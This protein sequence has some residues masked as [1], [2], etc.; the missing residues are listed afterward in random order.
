MMKTKLIL[1]ATLVGC[2]VFTFSGC[3]KSSSTKG[4]ALSA[5]QVSSQ[6]ALNITETLESGFGAF[7]LAGG[8][9]A[10]GNLG[11]VP[12]GRLRLNSAGDPLCGTIADTTLD[13]STNE[14][15][16][17]ASVKGHI[18]FA[19]TC[20]NGVVSGFNVTDN[21]AIAESS[22][23]F[24]VAFKLVE[25]LTVAAVNPN[26]D[27]TNITLNGSLSF[28]GDYTFKS[29]ANKGTG[30]QNYAYVFHTVTADSNGQLISGSADFTTS[31]TG[32]TGVWNYTGTVTF[33]GDGKA[34]IVINGTTYH[35][36][37]DTGVV[38]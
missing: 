38:S 19:F 22:S 23:D 26:N 16:T 35:V 17:S 9:N 28:G 21:L 13:Y 12:K 24:S 33:L 2:A 30:S 27:N 20:S 7:S 29:G 10:P 6:I 3:K 32:S 11:L 15:G 25:D 5:K 18:K 31:G 34:S 37:L 36:D 8:L 4:P 14:S 1:I